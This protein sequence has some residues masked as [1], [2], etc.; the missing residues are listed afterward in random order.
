MEREVR[1]DLDAADV[2][3]PSVYLGLNNPFILTATAEM[4]FI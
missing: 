3:K 1:I 4:K 2:P